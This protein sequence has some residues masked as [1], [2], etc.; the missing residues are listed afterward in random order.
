MLGKIS[1]TR[2]PD[3]RLPAQFLAL[4]AAGPVI[5]ALTV[6]WL[7]TINDNPD[8]LSNGAYS[9][10]SSQF[11]AFAIGAAIALFADKLSQVG[12]RAFLAATGILLACG[13][14]NALAV[15]GTL[16]PDTTLHARRRTVEEP[17]RQVVLV[18]LDGRAL[19]VRLF[20]LGFRVGQVHQALEPAV[21]GTKNDARQPAVVEQGRQST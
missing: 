4:I 16:A 1:D 8:F 6:V 3:Q 18:E 7:R 12:D 15:N 20:L 11:D 5:R 2:V 21:V 9:L 14:L 19:E 13:Q 10:T 17:V